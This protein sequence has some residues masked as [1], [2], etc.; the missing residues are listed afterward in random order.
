MAGQ[1]KEERRRKLKFDIKLQRRIKRR[2][3]EGEPRSKSE[4]GKAADE[5]LFPV[6]AIGNAFFAV[7]LL[8]AIE[9][10]EEERGL[11][12]GREADDE[13]RTVRGDKRL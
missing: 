7:F 8:F 12:L 10:G 5:A 6:G 11:V 9:E 1:K 3:R 13:S 4:S 2:P